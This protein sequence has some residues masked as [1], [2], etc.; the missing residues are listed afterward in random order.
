MANNSEENLLKL[1]K[2]RFDSIHVTEWSRKIA[3]F[4]FRP[5]NTRAVPGEE[6]DLYD[7]AYRNKNILLHS[8]DNIAKDFKKEH[9]E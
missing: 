2:T 9:P 3:E 4:V 5:Q 6:S 8:R 7:I 1:N